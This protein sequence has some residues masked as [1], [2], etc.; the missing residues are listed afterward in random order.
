[1]AK[2]IG[3]KSS[4]QDNFLEPLAPT[5]VSATDVG[6]NRPYLLTATGTN[7]QGGAV[8]LVITMPVTSPSATGY[9]ITSTPATVT[10]TSTSTSFNT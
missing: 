3:R 10:K 1:M 7:G 6:T 5:S 2:H 8:D 9:T 4:A